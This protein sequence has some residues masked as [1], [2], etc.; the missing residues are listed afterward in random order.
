MKERGPKSIPNKIIREAEMYGGADLD[1]FEYDNKGLVEYYD[2]EDHR[3]RSLFHHPAHS[4]HW[5]KVGGEAQ[6]EK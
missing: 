5:K 6:G 1:F 2:K 4:R 3:S